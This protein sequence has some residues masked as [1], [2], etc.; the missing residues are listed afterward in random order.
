MYTRHMRA[1]T[2]RRVS[3]SEQVDSGL[4][5]TAQSAT[6]TAALAMRG[7]ELVA[8]LSDEGLSGKNMNRP[9]LS[10]ALDRLDR[11]EADVLVVSKIDWLSR[12]L[13]DFATLTERAKRRGWSVVALDVGVDPTTA[14]GEMVTSVMATFAQF[15][16][17]IIAQRTSEGLQAMKARGV[18]LGRPVELADDVRHRIA[19]ERADG[20]SLRA[21]GDDLNAEAVPTARGGRWYASTVRAVL[22]SLA[23]DDLARTA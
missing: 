15:E 10:K 14:A 5:L 11:G 6:I 7:W 16:R 1:I 23:L 2:Y 22:E 21:I 12:S 9:A 4:G 17:R 3:T 13:L 8:D 18:R 19:A 20:R